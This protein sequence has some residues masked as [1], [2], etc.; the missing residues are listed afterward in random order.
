MFTYNMAASNKMQM[1][2][3][4]D[5]VTLLGYGSPVKSVQMALKGVSEFMVVTFVSD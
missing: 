1:V 3:M 4:H 2:L 5:N